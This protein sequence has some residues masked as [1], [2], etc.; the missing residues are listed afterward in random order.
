MS[1]DK[2]QSRKPKAESVEVTLRRDGAWWG[3]EI[4]DLS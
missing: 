1:L 3:F 2:P 4:W